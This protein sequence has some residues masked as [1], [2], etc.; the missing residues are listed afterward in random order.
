MKDSIIN[1]HWEGPM[2]WKEAIKKGRKKGYVLYQICGTH[3]VYGS[4]IPLYIGKTERFA[5][6]KLK[7]HD[8]WVLHEEYDRVKVR[9]GSVGKWFDWDHWFNNPSKSYPAP[10]GQL[11]SQLADVEKLLVLA[12]QPLYNTQYKSEETVQIKHDIRIF[13]TGQMGRLL[14]EISGTYFLNR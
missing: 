3:L 6:V 12:N 9:L 13:N 7:E 4:D 8:W 10:K 1:V 2:E 14:P 5:S 11:K